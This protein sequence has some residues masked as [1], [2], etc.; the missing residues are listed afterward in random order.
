ML[1]STTALRPYTPDDAASTL[2]CFRRA[3]HGTASHDYDAEQI[4]SWAAVDI[5]T[6]SCRRAKTTTWVAERHGQ[7]VGFG[8]IDDE[9]YIDMMFVDPDAGR[10]GVASALLEQLLMLAKSRGLG[11]LTVHASVTARPFFESHGFVITA[12]TQVELRGSVLT[13]YRMRFDLSYLGQSSLTSTSTRSAAR[14]ASNAPTITRA[15]AT[16]VPTMVVVDS[17]LSGRCRTSRARPLRKSTAPAK[18]IGTSAARCPSCHARSEYI[19]EPKRMPANGL[20]PS[21]PRAAASFT[22]TIRI[23]ASIRMTAAT[24]IVADYARRRRRS[25]GLRGSSRA[26]HPVERPPG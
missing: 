2:R 6:W 10:L 12:E 19:S 22:P 15:T 21:H 26:N 9:G 5:A 23:A 11:E 4:Q 7:L 25:T 13:H 8:D 3:V 24:S 17:V 16:T 1:E 18:I 20:M 14:L